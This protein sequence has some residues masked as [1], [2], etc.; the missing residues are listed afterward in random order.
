[1]KIYTGGGDRGKTGLFSG[2]RVSKASARVDAY[3]DVDELNSVIGA[4]IASIEPEDEGLFQRL[5]QIQ[6]RLFGAGAWL[7]VTSGSESASLLEAF[8]REHV[9]WLEQSI[10]EMDEKLSPLKQFILPGGCK[11][12][13]CAHIARTVCRRAERHAVFAL[14]NEAGT[15]SEDENARNVVAFLNRLSDYF[16]V[17]ARYL[18]QLA[19]EPDIIWKKL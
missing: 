6:S 4:L 13:A 10:D 11:A 8:A 14:E 1:M 12:S 15:I 19:G 3:G 17:L 7:A 18:N 5:R 9:Q 2:E 16:F